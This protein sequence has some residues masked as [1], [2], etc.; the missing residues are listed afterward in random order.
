MKIFGEFKNNEL[1][2]VET[3]RLLLRQRTLEDAA[4]MYKYACLEEVCYPAGF[5]PVQSVDEEIHYLNG[6]Y[7]ERLIEQNLPSGYGITLKGK[8]KVI[9]SVDFNKRHADD[10]LEMGYV[11][12]PKYWGKGIVP[13]AGRAL[14][15]IAFT[16]L[17]LCKI[18]ISCYDYNLQS[19]AVAQKL[20][21]IK[22][23]ERRGIKDI[24]GKPC[25]DLKY[26]L[27]K[28]EWEAAKSAINRD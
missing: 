26:G 28:A 11:L 9:G 21:F 15:E 16:Q 18:V 23:D 1:P 22:E 13:E 27:L 8:N 3:D 12:H 24:M 10:I 6:V 4:D 19:Q 25:S 2:C 7:K 14:I 20:G 17:N 5:P